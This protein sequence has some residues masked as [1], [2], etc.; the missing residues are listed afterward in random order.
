MAIITFW[1]EDRQSN[2]SDN[3]S[4]NISSTNGDRKKFKDLNC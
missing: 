3:I 4:Y 1:S 2:K